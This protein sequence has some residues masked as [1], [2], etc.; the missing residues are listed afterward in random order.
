MI[1]GLTQA[2][3][4][5]RALKHRVVSV[6]AT[7]LNRLPRSCAL[8]LGG[9]AGWTAWR[10]SARHRTAAE[11][12]ITD[13]LGV[14]SDQARALIRSCA[15]GF[16]V[17]LAQAVRLETMRPDRLRSEVKLFGTSHLREALRQGKGCFVV[18]AHLGNW[19][20]LAAAISSEAIPL[21]VVARRP[22]DTRLAARLER[23]RGR[24]GIETLWRD[25]G[26]RSVIRALESGRAVGVLID[27]ATA[28][29]GARIPFFGMPAW[30]PTGPARIAAR[31]GVPVVGARIAGNA[32][33]G[34]AGVIEPLAAGSPDADAR[35][36]TLVWTQ[37]IEEWIREST[38]QW[39]WMHD[40]WKHIESARDTDVPEKEVTA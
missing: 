16:G 30:T 31:Y 10:C 19:E 12:R 15:I 14:E 40:R 32:R 28:V 26:P 27:Q 20:L 22:G 25:S 21:S 36:A 24:W 9:A 1:A 5:R 11:R 13:A 18:G 23:L 39:V 34:Y 35:A 6:C 3:P 8:R 29:S 33:T 17:E 4:L 38:A 2:R 37:H 7:I